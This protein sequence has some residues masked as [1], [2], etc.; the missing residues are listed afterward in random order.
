VDIRIG[1]GYPVFDIADIYLLFRMERTMTERRARLT[2]PADLGLIVQQA[3]LGRGLSQT[4][5][6]ERLG[7]SQ[8]SISEIESGR[9]TIYLRR[10][11]ELLRETGVELTAEWDDDEAPR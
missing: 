8:R 11:F 5:L 1:G 10:V 2:S 4:A 9:T 3:R 7:I 6:A